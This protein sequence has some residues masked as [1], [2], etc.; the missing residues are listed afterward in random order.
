MKRLVCV[1]L[2]GVGTAL[3]LA[4]PAF[5]QQKAGQVTITDTRIE[6]PPGTKIS[7]SDQKALNEVLRKYDNSLYKV[8]TLKEGKVA[9]QG[10]LEDPRIDATLAAE[11]KKAQAAG[12]S[13]QAVQVADFKHLEPP[14]PGGFQ[15]TK[16][17]ELIKA[18]KPILEKYSKK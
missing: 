9:V 10:R 8:E 17:K 15:L 2:L 7:D 16:S 4:I 5:A 14:P 3:I 13:V 18:L 12:A 1:L 11:V 6:I